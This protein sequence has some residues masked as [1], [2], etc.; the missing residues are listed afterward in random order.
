[1]I[2]R[3]IL[4][5][6]I[7]LIVSTSSWAAG[8]LVLMSETSAPYQEVADTF[9][10]KLQQ[11][12]PAVQ[13]T[14]EPSLERTESALSTDTHL[15]VSIGMR[16][17]RVALALNTR[18]PVLAVLVPKDSFN[19]LVLSAN[20]VRRPISA[21]YLDQPYSRQLAMIRLAFPERRSVGVLLREQSRL[22]L[23]ALLASAKLQKIQVN[24]ELISNTDE[25][26]PSLEYLL[27]SSDLLL[28]LPDAMLYNKNDIRGVLLTSYHYHVPLIGYSEA[29]VRAGAI[30]ALYSKPQ[31]IGYQAAEVV[32]HSIGASLPA[33]Q[34]PKYFTVS[35]NQQV[36]RSLN[37][38]VPDEMVLQRTLQ[39][40]EQE[41][42]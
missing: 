37:I 17:T 3:L 35:I 26:V 40:W 18:V 23:E 7:S 13:V 34:Y 20:E 6:S 21:I 32:S 12:R 8:V 36:A 29:L 15:L 1:M 24:G 33:P 38:L 5:S 41:Q 30:M 10:A 19:A 14:V 28:V 25:I 11:E 31:Q 2:Y 4:L 16:A 9:R 42:Q 27:A 39:R 22:K